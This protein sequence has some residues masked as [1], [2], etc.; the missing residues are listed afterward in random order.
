MA[1]IRTVRFHRPHPADADEAQTCGRADFAM[2]YVTP[3]RVLV[4]VAGDIDATNRQALG[5][6]VD[7]HIRVSQELILDLSDVDFFG[8]Q[9]FTALHYVSVRCAGRDMD[10]MLVCNRSVRRIL[11]IC[12]PDGELPMVDDTGIALARLDHLAR[13][14]QAV[15]PRCHFAPARTHLIRRKFH[16]ARRPQGRC[17]PGPDNAK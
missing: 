16:A 14:R 11:Q 15:V 10:W 7:R 2:H 3:K 5:R 8:S 17:A 1:A 12:D 9:G 4:T 6:F 13:C